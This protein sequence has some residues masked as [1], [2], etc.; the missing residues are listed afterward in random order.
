MGLY[1]ADRIGQLLGNGNGDGP[2]LRVLVLGLT[3][4]ENVPDLR[5]T[6]VVD[7]VEKLAARGHRIEVH[8]PLADA[9]EAR[10]RYGLE[11]RASLDGAEPYDCLIGAVPHRAYAAFTAA[12]F[13]GLV[14]PGGLVADIKGMWRHIVLPEGLR[15]WRM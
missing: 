11:L 3:F 9:D 15:V 10:Q 6:K 12:T 2:P 7:I 8:D 5:N 14:R 4:K 1:I 13:G